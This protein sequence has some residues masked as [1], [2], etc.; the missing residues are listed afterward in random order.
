MNAATK[1]RMWEYT[2]TLVIV[3]MITVLIWLYA[4]SENIKLQEPIQFD[5]RFVP[6]AGQD[7][8]IAPSELT[9]VTVTVRCATSQYTTLTGLL[10]KPLELEISPQQAV[11]KSQDQGDV[12]PELVIKVDLRDHLEKSA[13]GELGTTFVEV[14]PE[15][16]DVRVVEVKQQSLT[17]STTQLFEE[18]DEGIG[19][20]VI[21]PPEADI[22][23]PRQLMDRASGN[24]TQLPGLEVQLTPT[25]KEQIKEL[26]ENM[27]WGPTPVRIIPVQPK[28]PGQREDPWWLPLTAKTIEPLTSQVT[29]TVRKPTDEHELKSVP[30]LLVAPWKS[31]QN[32]SIRVVSDDQDDLIVLDKPI[33]IS[34]PVDEIKK[35]KSG[36]TIV[37]AELRLTGQ[38]IYNSLESEAV[39]KL[40]DIDLPPDVRLESAI[41]R[42]E[43]T[44]TEL[45]LGLTPNAPQ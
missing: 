19:S 37:W 33:K 30:I 21:D 35:I 29:I 45:L 1:T 28:L 42:V 44:V 20:V 5:V 43:F 2:Q 7:L 18:L 13:V 9:G 12:V 27:L 40:V 15:V 23:L 17:I 6:P 31:L 26:S 38:E 41:P 10:K 25:Q 22:S 8:I 14:H 16:L 4:E 11:V 36:E 24:P 39:S 3:T 34:G 32:Y